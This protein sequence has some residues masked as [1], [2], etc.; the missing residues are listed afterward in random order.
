MREYKTKETDII[1]IPKLAEHV[2][3]CRPIYLYNK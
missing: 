3:L 1:W 2:L